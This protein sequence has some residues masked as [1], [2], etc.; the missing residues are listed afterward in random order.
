MGDGRSEM[1]NPLPAARGVAHDGEEEEHFEDVDEDENAEEDIET[2]E[3][4]VGEAAEEGIGQEWNPEHAGGQ[5]EAG[6]ELAV[7]GVEEG[8]G[9]GEGH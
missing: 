2:G 8:E 5:E 4:Q 9:E 3:G 6:F 7:F 1:G